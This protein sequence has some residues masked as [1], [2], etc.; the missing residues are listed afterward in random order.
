MG[1][2]QSTGL[3]DSVGI[4]AQGQD[5]QG[6]REQVPIKATSVSQKMQEGVLP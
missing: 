3:V 6:K 1:L 2:P 4:K 5:A